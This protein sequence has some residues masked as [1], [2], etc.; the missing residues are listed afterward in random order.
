MNTRIWRI[1]ALWGRRK[2]SRLL[3]A[4]LGLPYVAEGKLPVLRTDLELTENY[5]LALAAWVLSL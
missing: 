2:S 5:I 4:A 3:E 1:E